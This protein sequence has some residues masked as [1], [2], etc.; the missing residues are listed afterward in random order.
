MFQKVLGG[1]GNDFGYFSEVTP[2][3]GQIIFGYSDGFGFG[4]DDFYLVKTDANGDTMWSKAYGNIGSDIGYHMQQSADGGY[5][6]I[7]ETGSFG[8]GGVDFYAVKANSMGDTLWTKAYGSTGDEFGYYVEETSDSGYIFCGY[9]TTMGAGNDDAYVV[10]TNSMGDTLWTKTYGS[11]GYDY[12][13]S[14]KQTMDSGFVI[15]GT[16]DGFGVGNQ[17]VYVIRTDAM[18]DTLWTKVYGGSGFEGGWTIDETSDSGYV[19]CGWANSF[20]AGGYDVYLIR[21]DA[22]GDTL[23]TKSYGGA[24]D[25]IG[26]T[27]TETP[28]SGYLVTGYTYSFGAINGDAYA[29]AL[30]SSGSIIWSKAYG[31]ALGDAAH[32]MSATPDNGYAIGGYSYSFSSGDSRVYLIQTDSMGNSGSCYET[33]TATIV[34]NAVDNVSGT[35]TMLGVGSMVN[36]TNTVVSPSATISRVE[37]SVALVGSNNLSCNSDSSGSATVLVT[38][39][40][41]VYLYAWDDVNSQTTATANTLYADTFQVVITDGFGCMDSVSVTLTE[42]AAFLPVISTTDLQCNGDSSGV[43]SVTLSGGVGPS[44]YL[45]DDAANQTNASATGLIG[46]TYMVMITDSTGCMDSAS[47]TVIEPG[48]LSLSIANNIPVTCNAD[49]SASAAAVIVGGT[50]PFTYLWDDIMVQTDSIALNLASGNYTLAVTDSN[51]CTFSAT[52]SIGFYVTAS[53][54]SPICGGICDGSATAT[55]T[56][57]ASPMA[58]AW[59]DPQNQS[60]SN[61]TSLCGGNTFT[62]TVTEAGGCTGVDSVSLT[63]NTVLNLSI[64]IKDVTCFNNNNGEALAIVSGGSPPYT[65]LWPASGITLNQITGQGPGTY[66]LILTDNGGCVKTTTATIVE[67]AALAVSSTVVSTS[68][69][70]SGDGQISLVVSGGTAPY[71]YTWD[72]PNTSTSKDV[73]D[74]FTG[75]YVV[76]IVDTN[77]CPL[78][79][80]IT[81]TAP[82]GL[83]LTGSFTTDT[84][85]N[86]GAAWVVVSG[87]TS[88]YSYAWSVTSST[89]DT[90]YSL[91]MG[92]YTVTVTD[93]NSCS[94]ILTINVSDV[95]NPM[96]QATYE[97]TLDDFGRS[98]DE[99]TGGGFIITG[100][101]SSF[102]EGGTDVYLVRTDAN[103][104]YMWSKTYGGSANDEGNSV[105]ETSDG[106]FIIAGYTMSFGAGES[107]IYV[108]KTNSSG[109]TTWT[110]AYGGLSDDR[111]FS[112]SELS[113]GGYVIA[114]GT[115][116]YGVGETDVYLMEIDAN[117]ALQWTKTYGG[118]GF[119]YGYSVQQTT[120]NGFVI[121]G[122]TYSFGAGDANAYLIKTDNLGALT[123]AWAFGGNADD[124]L[125]S[126]RQTSDGGYIVAGYSKSFGNGK[127]DVFVV[128]TDNAGVQ[129]WSKTFG[130]SDI[131]IARSVAESSAGGYVI[132]GSSKSFGSLSEKVYL[133]KI[134]ANGDEEW[135][136]TYGGAFHDRG[137]DVIQTAD[138]GYAIAGN[139][140]SFAESVTAGPREFYLIKTDYLGRSN[141]NQNIITSTVLD[142]SAL[143]ST[144]V[145]TPGVGGG[146]LSTNTI[147]TANPTAGGSLCFKTTGIGDGKRNITKQGDLIVYPNPNNG[148]FSVSIMMDLRDKDASLRVFDIKGVVVYS[149]TDLGTGNV[150][151]QIELDNIDNGMYFVQLIS[152]DGSI[153][154]KIICQ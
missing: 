39:G 110:M 60:D 33:S 103:G 43:V 87:G 106:G 120:D 50:S 133:I 4:S 154:K 151:K 77:N 16:T 136:K 64:N 89:N 111:G 12:A 84:G 63:G 53:G 150:A 38:G 153:T 82:N 42:P 119:D 25:D 92:S 124:E 149:D 70:T 72:D 142:T 61:A 141:C 52:T 152:K 105:I 148:K 68:C 18:G 108:I 123:W 3:S 144:F 135:A 41:L 113:G 132:A 48:A 94:S 107:D 65:Y 78:D 44:T 1:T 98:M 49:S 117:G 145:I 85:N 31:G 79:D 10:R 13:Y 22:A 45:W 34:T 32:T 30:T 131:D 134:D 86:S 9:S 69:N 11:V 24:S 67:P 97:G 130:D 93:D 102:G 2:D 116:S 147:A 73:T 15:T 47:G 122:Y 125:N 140:T 62:V 26:L 143:Y 19:I 139:A 36:S 14:I 83:A 118:A 17:D 51:G 115:N 8:A 137:W 91:S 99:V 29:M 96:F 7:G 121:A 55:T 126:V 100:F 46:G 66:T 21:T 5:I 127:E 109:D 101:T 59:N 104:N 88:P 75:D 71:Y 74:L 58:Y 114:G 56:G 57:G 54:V 138:Q 146:G 27:V 95:E 112:I 23:W 20:S 28:D 80:T 35:T 40:T 37:Y 6:M 76:N 129:T 128:K 81:V 90:L